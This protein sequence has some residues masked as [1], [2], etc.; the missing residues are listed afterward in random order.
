MESCWCVQLFIH[1]SVQLIS[2]F[3]AKN[4]RGQEVIDPSL[5]YLHSCLQM[6]SIYEHSNTYT[7]RYTQIRAHTH[8]HTNAY[9]CWFGSN[10]PV[11]AGNWQRWRRHCETTSTIMWLNVR[12]PGCVNLC[13][14]TLRPTMHYNGSGIDM[15]L[16]RITSHFLWEGLGS[17][18]ASRS[19]TPP[20]CC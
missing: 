10:P 4:L 13:T 18:T 5:V 2:V 19:E 11:A 17:S 16:D 3:D 12:V 14:Q 7:H 15:L 20:S 8:T 6:S 9:I 1:S